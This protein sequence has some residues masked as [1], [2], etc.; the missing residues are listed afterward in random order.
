MIYKLYDGV[1]VSRG[2]GAG[3]RG[4]IQKQ[5]LSAKGKNNCSVTP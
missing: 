4:R 2:K 1:F 3:W 5:S